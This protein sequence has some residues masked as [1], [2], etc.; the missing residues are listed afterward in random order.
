MKWHIWKRLVSG[1]RFFGRYNV[2]VQSSIELDSNLYYYIIR[3]SPLLPIPCRKF[4]GEY[5][6]LG[7]K[8]LPRFFHPINY[9]RF[10][11]ITWH[12]T[13]S[14]W[15]KKLDERCPEVDAFIHQVIVLF[16]VLKAI[17]RSDDEIAIGYLLWPLIVSV[18]YPTIRFLAK[19]N[20]MYIS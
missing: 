8:F 19:L 15:T 5:V 18:D 10:H 6:F 17:S 14:R 13:V 3:A 7:N 20:T 16:I 2:H 9:P 12:K 11:I 1:E 4:R